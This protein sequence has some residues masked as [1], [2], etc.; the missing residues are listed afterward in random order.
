[1]LG[2]YGRKVG[3]EDGREVEDEELEI[4]GG[5]GGIHFFCSSAGSLQS[6]IYLGWMLFMEY[7]SLNTYYRIE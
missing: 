4:F 6:I 7:R 5:C 2:M 1:M 3:S